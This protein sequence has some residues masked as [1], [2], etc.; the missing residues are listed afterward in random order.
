MVKY[1]HHDHYRH[2][3]QYQDVRCTPA[4]ASEKTLQVRDFVLQE[5]TAVKNIQHVR[6]KKQKDDSEAT[7]IEEAHIRV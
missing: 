3:V 5:T 6:G 1:I 4:I 2:H 7:V